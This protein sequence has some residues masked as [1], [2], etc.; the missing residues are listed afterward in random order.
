MSPFLKKVALLNTIS[1][2]FPFLHL[3]PIHFKKNITVF[4]GENGTGKS[5]ILEALAVKLGCPAEGGSIN[6]NFKT[7][8]TH[9]D[10]TKDLRLTKSGK[11]IRDIFF[12]RSETYYT[13]LSEMRRLDNDFALGPKINSYYGGKDL[14]TISHGE[15]MKAL[16]SNRFKSESLY[17][18]DEPESSLSISSQID[19]VEKILR[20][21]KAG[22][23]FIIA[24]HSPILMAMPE[25]DLIQI[26]KNST[27]E[28]FFSK[29]NSYYLLKEL[30]N[31]DGHFLKEIIDY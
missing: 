7:E 4:I 12:Y 1:N 22:T 31:S 23:Q 13:F 10:Y 6:F 24:T 16:Y 20:L 3:F 11:K 17:I 28:T 18:L 14:H 21:S 25:I 29:T 2:D 9:L 27:Y 15:S 26:T 5:T 19:L 8:D 30:I